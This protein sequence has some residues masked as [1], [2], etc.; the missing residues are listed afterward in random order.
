MLDNAGQI[1]SSCGDLDPHLMRGALGLPESP[2]K[3]HVDRFNRFIG[4]QERDRHTDRHTDHATLSVA[5]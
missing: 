1:P 2:V 3:W 5:Q 4:A